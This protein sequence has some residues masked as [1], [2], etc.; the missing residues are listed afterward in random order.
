[1][2]RLALAAL[3]L[4]VSTGCLEVEKVTYS[5]DL[6]EMTGEIVYTG[7]RSDS[8]D[9]V[10][11]DYAQLM[12]E[13]VNGTKLEAENPGWNV[14]SKELY[15]ADGKLNGKVSIKFRE[16]SNL[17]IYK[18]DK[19]APYIYCNK[20]QTVMSTNGTNIQD[21]LAG[22]VAWDRKATKLEVTLANTGGFQQS[23]VSLLETWKVSQG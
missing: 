7:I 10:E 20:D 5:F 16:P 4:L 15:E 23:P 14:Q 11:E 2:K 9:N 1:M 21:V 22:C 13:F 6:A 3:A 18:H 17:G 8:A 12:N 19:K